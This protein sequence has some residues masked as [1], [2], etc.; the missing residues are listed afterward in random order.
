MNEPVL[1]KPV[2]LFFETGYTGSDLRDTKPVNN[3]TGYL[4]NSFLA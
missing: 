2:Q 4:K 3:R 1:K